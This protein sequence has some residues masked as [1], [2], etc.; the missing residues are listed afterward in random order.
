MGVICY[1]GIEEGGGDHGSVGDSGLD[2]AV[3]GE[4]AIVEASGCPAFD[5]AG[6][7]ADDVAPGVTHP[8]HCVGL[9]GPKGIPPH[10]V[11]Q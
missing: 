11:S 9:F 5:V 8:M 6:Q 7:P 1:E 3:R 4:V 10:S 2:R